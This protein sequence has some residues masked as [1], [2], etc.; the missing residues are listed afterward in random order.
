MTSKS[1]HS[2]LAPIVLPQGP[3]VD[4]VR[5]YFLSIKETE[6]MKLV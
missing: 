4:S 2:D 5:D 3:P 1:K 6:L